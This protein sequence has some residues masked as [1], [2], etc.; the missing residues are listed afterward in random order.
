MSYKSPFFRYFPYENSALVVAVGLLFC[1]LMSG[2]CS[3]N[4]ALVV[5]FT[6]PI[7]LM[8]PL[9]F[10][11]S[12]LLG[13]FYPFSNVEFL[14]FSISYI[15]ESLEHLLDKLYSNDTAKFYKTFLLGRPPDKSL[16]FLFQSL[17]LSHLL[18]ISGFHFQSILFSFDLLLSR[19][20]KERFYLSFLL[21]IASGYLL[22]VQLSPSVLR[23]FLSI[24]LTLLAPL[25]KRFTQS[26]NTFFLS[27]FLVFLILPDKSLKLGSILSFL[28][29]FGILFYSQPINTYLQSRFVQNSFYLV[30]KLKNR[31]KK[32]FCNLVSINFAVTITTLPY[33][34][35]HMQGFPP[36]AFV[37]N[38]FFPPLMLPTIF[39]S[40]FSIFC[41]FVAPL[42]EW[43]T[44]KILYAM[45][46]VPRPLTFNICL[47]EGADPLLEAL[48]IL[49]LALPILRSCH[50]TADTV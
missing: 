42:S 18:A 39:L 43:Y 41:P 7:A 9:V 28:A 45:E 14:D 30:P 32:F 1:P 3:Y 29:T 4:A 27:F 36:L 19:V 20:L 37:T 6:T 44:K 10:I 26:R 48:L 38:L 17:G 21:F 2:L 15:Q 23:S 35:L 40:L 31:V 46:L 25:C 50:K 34:F 49:V 12:V 5:L 22:L 47:P 8:H 33:I 16:R 13:F 24:F 11:L